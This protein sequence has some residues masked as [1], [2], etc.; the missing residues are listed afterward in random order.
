MS[1]N[2]VQTLNVEVDSAKL[3][4]QYLELALPTVLDSIEEIAVKIIDHND[5]YKK[6]YYPSVIYDKTDI[7]PVLLIEGW[8]K[9]K[10][11]EGKSFF[12]GYKPWKL[13]DNKNTLK[14]SIEY[15]IEVLSE[16]QSDLTDMFLRDCGN[17]YNY[18]FNNF[19]G[20]IG[21][22]YKL[23]SNKTFPNSLSVSLCHIYYGK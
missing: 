1:I 18:G 5:A 4:K 8:Y 17:G 11:N 15:I 12:N 9:S 21:I 22:G 19:D 16:N 20:D 7:L 10:D 23:I 13:F 3:L 2:L 6:L 14:D